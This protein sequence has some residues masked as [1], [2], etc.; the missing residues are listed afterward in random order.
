MSKK[1]VRKEIRASL[2]SP[3]SE[4]DNTDKEEVSP[5]TDGQV[6]VEKQVE[7]DWALIGNLFYLH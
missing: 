2:Q 4:T 5:P 7:E 1:K 3:S 6:F